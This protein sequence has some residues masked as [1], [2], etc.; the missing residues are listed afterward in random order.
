MYMGDGSRLS[1]GLSRRA[2]ASAP[3][4]FERITHVL[5]EQALC[6]TLV[7]VAQGDNSDRAGAV[8][9]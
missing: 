8:F 3:T 5:H 9:A 2:L 7:V 6:A 4:V 1:S